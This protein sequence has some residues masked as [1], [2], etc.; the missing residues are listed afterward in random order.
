MSNKR[1]SRL[2][3]LAGASPQSRPKA[4]PQGRS[5]QRTIEESVGLGPMD[6]VTA[7]KIA[8]IRA[9]IS[10]NES[11]QRDFSRRRNIPGPRG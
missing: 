9:K 10:R 6:P 3:R 8:S 4:R 5:E 7:S 11:L 2:S 1:P